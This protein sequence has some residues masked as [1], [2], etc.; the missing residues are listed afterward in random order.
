MIEKVV[1][2][3]DKRMGLSAVKQS[4]VLKRD[5]ACRLEEKMEFRVLFKTAHAVVIEML[6][7]GVY[8][9]EKEYTVVVNGEEVMTSKKVIQTIR[10]LKPDTAYEIQV[11]NEDGCSPVVTVYTD[12][13][14]VTLDV[15]QFG[16]KGDGEHDDTIFIQ[17]AINACPKH[18]RVLVPAGVW[19]TSALFLKDDLVLEF[20]EGATLSAFTDRA[21]FPILP[22]LI[23]STDGEGEYNLGTWEGDPEEMFASILTGI[24]VKNVVITGAGVLDGN[25]SYENWWEG[26]GREKTGGAYRPRMIFLN[27]CENVVVHGI[28]V[29][30]SP[31]WNLHPYFSNHLRYIDLDI[32]NPKISPNTD[33]IDPESV[34]GLEIVGVHFSL[35]DDCIAVKSGRFYMGHKYKKSSQHIEIRQCYMRHGHGSVTLGSEMAA[36]V[37]HLVC[38]DCIF[39]DTDRGLRVK[40]RRGRGNDAVIEDIT[41]ENIKMEGVLTPFVVNS[42]YW[43]CDPDGHSEYVRTKEPLPVDE[44]TPFI[45]ELHF[46]D[47]EAHNCHVAATFIYGLPEAKIEKITFENVAVDFA[48]NPTPEYPAMMADVEPC[49]NKGVYINN[50]KK[51]VMKNVHVEGAKGEPIELLNVDQVIRE[52]E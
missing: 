33:G 47:I 1:S 48:E 30:N 41:F 26:N 17:A 5:D 43:C 34:D 40:T 8:F 15:R 46:K 10:D 36:G 31:A 29:Q 50:V 42:Y 13:E 3:N 14:F 22:G 11:K 20:A 44:R 28:K 27:H 32:Q 19:R 4:L 35:G 23:P 6:H 16:A 39:E 12:Y 25:A 45:K 52:D 21:K 49:T 37:R 9:T 38:R 18:G 24:N 7:Y 2:P 51:L